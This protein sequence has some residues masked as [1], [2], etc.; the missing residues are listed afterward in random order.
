[1][2]RWFHDQPTR[3]VPAA[4]A[5]VEL[6]SE[7]GNQQVYKVDTRILTPPE[8]MPQLRNELHRALQRTESSLQNGRFEITN[9][10][11]IRDAQGAVIAYQVTLR[12][13]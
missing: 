7:K 8:Q 3:G 13:K 9:V 2:S 1:P 4:S 10:E 5:Q 6:L 12:K 11:A